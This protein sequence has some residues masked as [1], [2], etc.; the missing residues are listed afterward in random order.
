MDSSSR[1]GGYLFYIF[2]CV[3]VVNLKFCIRKQDSFPCFIIFFDDLQFGR[4]FFI[5]KDSP[6]LGLCTVFRDSYNKIIHRAEVVRCGCFTDNISTV[7]DSDRAGISTFICEHLRFAICRQYDRLCGS[8]VIGTIFLNGQTAHQI[9]GKTCTCQQIRIRFSIICRLNDLEGLFDNLVLGSRC[10]FYG[11][12]M[13][14]FIA[15]VQ[16]IFFLIQKVPNRRGDLFYE[17]F[18]KIKILN[19]GFP[20][21]VCFKGC[22][23]RAGFIKDTCLSIRM[24]DIFTGK[25]PIN[26]SLQRGISLRCASGLCIFFGQLDGSVHPLIFK[27]MGKRHRCLIIRCVSESKGI[28]FL[29]VNI[30]I[31][32]CLQLLNIVTVPDWEVRFIRSASVASCCHLF[33]QGVLFHNDISG[34]ITDITSRIQ[35]VNAAIQRILGF[36]ILLHNRNRRFLAC[37]LESNAAHYYFYIAASIT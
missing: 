29:T 3:H 2:L 23:L 31:F 24:N 10:P 9:S 33:N 13:I 36:V 1:I 4:K 32:R 19:A 30:I 5:Q 27:S 34:I 15:A 28:H 37:I 6:C 11:F 16:V 18:S 26:C 35:S 20:F 14:P 12:N 22:N 8:K 21:F 25:K 17:I 7:R